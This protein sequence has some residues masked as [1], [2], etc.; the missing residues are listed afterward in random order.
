MINVGLENIESIVFEGEQIEQVY[1]GSNLIFSNDN[2][3]ECK[4]HLHINS[5]DCSEI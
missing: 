3:E 1:Y 5:K 2:T 4:E